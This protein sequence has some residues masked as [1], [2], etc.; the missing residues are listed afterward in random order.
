MTHRGA[1]AVL[2]LA[3]L[4]AAAPVPAVAQRGAGPGAGEGAAVPQGEPVAGGVLEDREFGVRTRQ[5]GLDRRVEMYQWFRDPAGGYRQVW[6]AAPV[7]SSG[8]APGHD[9][10][11]AL[12]LD[13]QRWWAPGPMLDGYPLD[14]E[15]LKALGRWQV[16]RPSFSRLPANFAATFQPEGDGLG[17]ALNPL[18]PQVGDLRIHWRELRLP[19]LAGR[20]ELRDGRWR[21]SASTAQAVLNA[22]P[23]PPVADEPLLGHAGGRER[24]LLAG[25]VVLGGLLGGLAWVLRFARR[26]R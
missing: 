3:A 23:L 20:V 16:F 7:D 17:S 11:S 1:V 18:D 14:L 5:F 21:L 26:R 25:A 13:G 12:P 2:G 15:V 9:N 8:F 4:V 24:W 22:K 10:P 19:P 6:K